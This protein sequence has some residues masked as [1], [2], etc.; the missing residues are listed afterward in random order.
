MSLCCVKKLGLFASISILGG[1]GGGWGGSF[2]EGGYLLR[3]GRDETSDLHCVPIQRGVTYVLRYLR[4]KVSCL[5]QEGSNPLPEFRCSSQ[6]SL[7]K[8]RAYIGCGPGYRCV[9]TPAGYPYP[10]FRH[11]VTARLML[12]RDVVAAGDMTRDGACVGG[13]AG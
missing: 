8:R 5:E 1:G 4:A 6:S 9:D 10:R 13:A 12:C 3:V 2:S 7:L 11:Q